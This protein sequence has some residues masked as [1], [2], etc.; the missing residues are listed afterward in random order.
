MSQFLLSHE[1][2]VRLAVFGGVLAVMALWEAVRPIRTRT[3][4]RRLRWW[5][6]LGLSF[7]GSIAVRLLFPVAAVGVSVWAARENFGLL[8]RIDAPFAISFLVSMV[9]LDLV[10]YAQHVAFHRFGF[11]WRLHRVH[12]ADPEIDATT[13]IRFH[14]VE[15][16]ISMIVK[17]VAVA[18]LGAPAAAV[19]AFEIGLNATA[20]FNHANITLGTAID[21]LVRL[22]IVTPDMHRVHHSIFPDE[23]NANFGFNLSLWDR[24]FGT[25]RT[26][27]RDEQRLMRIGLEDFPGEAPIRLFWCLALP[28]S[29]AVRTPSTSGA[30]RPEKLR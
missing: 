5:T 9:V 23:Y 26:F 6:N 4:A 29:A 30:T 19:V 18:A 1:P 17:M 28:F 15:I 21:P 25:Y 13:G 20:M 22:A 24:L 2:V 11:L 10:V 16:M 7:T 3:H 12:H 27:P 14:P 8:N